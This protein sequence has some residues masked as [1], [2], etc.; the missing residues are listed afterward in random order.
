MVLDSSAMVS[1][2]LREADYRMLL[3]KI[4]D[5]DIVTVGA[6]TLVET[7]MVLSGLV[8]GPYSAE[9]ASI[10]SSVVR[11]SVPAGSYVTTILE[12]SPL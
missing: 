1:I 6:P 8:A 10:M 3:A 2:L 4:A 12:S 11:P 9:I 7:A 5:A